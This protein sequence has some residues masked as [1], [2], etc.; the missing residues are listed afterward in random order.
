MAQTSA[1]RCN[2]WITTLATKPAAGASQQL[3]GCERCDNQPRVNFSIVP[4]VGNERASVERCKMKREAPF[5]PDAGYSVWSNRRLSGP[6]CL[7]L[8]SA[9]VLLETVAIYC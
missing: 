5:W 7:N 9:S 3:S 8:E 4:V 2:F 6:V 1:E